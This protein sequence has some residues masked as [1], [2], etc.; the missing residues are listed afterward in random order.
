RESRSRLLRRFIAA[1]ARDR[2]RLARLVGCGL[3]VV[4]TQ[5]LIKSYRFGASRRNRTPANWVR[6][7]K[8]GCQADRTNSTKRTQ[9]LL[10]KALCARIWLIEST[11]D[12]SLRKEPFHSATALTTGN[13]LVA[14][15][16][17]QLA[18]VV[19]GAP[20][21]IEYGQQPCPHRAGA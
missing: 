5:T 14:I 19:G 18:E 12:S 9:S 17:Q 1:T 13:A 21:T 15:E 16:R 4:R 7:V 6:F 3:P 8:M 10:V 2:E 20:V 11:V